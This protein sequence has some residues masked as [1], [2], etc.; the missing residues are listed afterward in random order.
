[1][2]YTK[3]LQSFGVSGLAASLIAASTLTV[4]LCA[5]EEPS[6]PEPP[7]EKPMAKQGAQAAAPDFTSTSQLIGIN[8]F[9]EA[10]RDQQKQPKA[11]VADVLI[12]GYTGEVT[13]A[14]I[15]VGGFLGIGDKIVLVPAS[16]LK[17]NATER[18]YE[19]GWT[20]D[21]LA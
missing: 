2:T 12:D 6:M 16:S 4:G 10:A 18:R 20:N 15:S 8:V 11:E 13:H 3:K 5:Q 14:V 1:M 19:L 21:E 17:W 7:M 9:L